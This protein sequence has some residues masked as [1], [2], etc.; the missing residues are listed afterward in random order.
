MLRKQSKKR[1][2]SASKTV[3]IFGTAATVVP[4][5]MSAQAVSANPIQSPV[6]N[7]SI[8][9]LL[10]NAYSTSLVAGKS[11]AIDLDDV[12]QNADDLDYAVFVQFNSIADVSV[13]NDGDGKKLR[14][15]LKK[16][17]TTKVDLMV[18]V[19]ETE[20]YEHQRFTLTVQPNYALN[21]SGTAGIGDVI[22]YY[23]SHPAEFQSTDDYRRLLQAAVSSSAPAVNHPPVV[24]SDAMS[25]PGS[26]DVKDVNL[27]LDAN[28]SETIDLSDYFSDEDGDTLTYRIIEGTDH[29]TSGSFAYGQIVGG[30]QLELHAYGTGSMDFIVEASDNQSAATAAMTFRLSS[31][32]APE[33][34]DDDF[35]LHTIGD[36]NAFSIHEGQSAKIDLSR[37]FEEVGEGEVS[38]DFSVDDGYFVDGELAGSELTLQTTGSSSLTHLTVM[39]SD[40]EGENWTSQTISISP[41]EGSK[42]PDVA[43]NNSIA[44]AA[45]DVADYFA[46]S[47]TFDAS[48]PE[49][50][51]TAE[52]NGSLLTLGLQ[53]DSTSTVEVD[54]SNENGLTIRDRFQVEVSDMSPVDIG[55][56]HMNRDGDVYFAS[57]DLSAIFP[58][59]TDFRVADYSYEL[60][61]LSGYS[62]YSSNNMLMLRT[63]VPSDDYLYVDVE[64]I[65]DEEVTGT[66]RILF[67]QSSEP[68]AL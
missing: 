22:R 7:A 40:D 47:Y 16:T 23:K 2:W 21:S 64:A 56:Q 25:E 48:V 61:D 57:V 10:A 6:V 46:G 39:A 42:L 65:N 18:W 37:M 1:Q 12:F 60:E 3:R 62:D 27:L 34:P 29:P 43:Y 13:S 45:I 20:N 5:A 54:A 33:E 31:E 67:S 68:F 52:P 59:A 24:Y 49:G 55:V 63:T 11:F 53:P 50:P 15:G 4:L 38:Y 30:S 44:T 66:Y 35:I 28:N 41:A 26:P 17:G 51:A 32:W 14:I 19:P 8:D 9:S 36:G 58:N